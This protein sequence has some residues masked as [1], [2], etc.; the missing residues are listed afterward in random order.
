MFARTFLALACLL[1]ATGAYAAEPAPSDPQNT[2][3]LDLEYGRVV[4]RMRP[5]WA[6]KHVERIKHLVRGGF[7]DGIVFHRVIDGFMAQAGDPSGTGAGG[8]GRKLKAEF[9]RTPQVRGIVSMAR[10]GGKDTADSQ[11]FI[12]LKDSRKDLDGNYT[13]WGEV[14]DGMEYV[15]KIKKGDANRNGTVKTPDRIVHL[16]LAADVAQPV[17]ADPMVLKSSAAA[18]EAKEFSAIEFRCLAADNRP[19]AAVQSALAEVWT[20]G[21]LAGAAKAQNALTFAQGSAGSL[22]TACKTY[23]QAFLLVLANQELSKT[24]GPIAG[25]NAAFAPAGYTCKDYVA[26][27][28][29]ADKTQA[30]LVDLWSFGFIQGFKNVGQPNMEIPFEVR[31]Q[32]L[33]VAA[34]ACA[35]T[36]ELNFVDLMG[37]VAAKV[38]LK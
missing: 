10:S 28:N 9:T 17:A 7:Y 11:W 24:S 14:I 20:H 29:G 35:K 19:G 18:V 26:A 30:D 16:Q 2:L 13:A 23:P 6:P 36:P 38:K 25:T 31:P 15:D 33:T 4:I 8:S 1:M 21:Y 34:N 37:Q 3:Y 27:R 22:L 12:V 5:D 32:L